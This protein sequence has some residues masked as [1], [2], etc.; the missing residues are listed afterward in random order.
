MK[1]LKDRFLKDNK[2]ME[3]ALQEV[4]D[5]FQ[6]NLNDLT[7]TLIAIEETMRIMTEEHN[8]EINLSIGMI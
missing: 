2:M 4:I 1:Q 7:Y 5:S 6:Q 8:T 3:M